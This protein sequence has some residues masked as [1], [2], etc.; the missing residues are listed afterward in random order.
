MSVSSAW[1]S[2]KDLNNG[3]QNITYK[4]NFKLL[5]T[6]EYLILPPS[7]VSYEVFLNDQSLVNTS[8]GLGIKTRIY[9]TEI[10]KIPK[11][12]LK[13]GDNSIKIVAAGE[14][15]LGGFKNDTILFTSNNNRIFLEQIRNLFVND[16]HILFASLALI[17][18]ILCFTERVN[19]FETSFF[20][21]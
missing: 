8:I 7:W 2:I 9:A 19:S 16:I 5:E 4:K 6:F 3:Y 10:I 17:I 1:N 12:Y 13:I 20:I 18:G 14:K 11:S 15:N 21:N